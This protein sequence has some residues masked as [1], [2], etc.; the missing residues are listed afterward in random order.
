MADELR[1]IDPAFSCEVVLR[2]VSKSLY[3]AGR[4]QFERL[5][6]LRSLGLSGYFEDAG[7]H[8]RHH[9]LMKKT[10]SPLLRCKQII[11]EKRYRPEEE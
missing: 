7:F 2:G 6:D 4:G 5:K 8:T 11:Q 10:C 9:H 1:F 3:E